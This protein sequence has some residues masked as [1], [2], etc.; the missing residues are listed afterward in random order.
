M[1]VELVTRDPAEHDAWLDEARTAVDRV[2]AA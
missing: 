2:L 1:P